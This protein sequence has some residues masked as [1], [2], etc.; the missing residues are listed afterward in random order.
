MIRK[1]NQ[2]LI[3]FILHLSASPLA[4]AI[5]NETW[6]DFSDIGVNTLLF[7]AMIIP[8]VKGD[9]EGTKQALFSIG[10]ARAASALTKSIIRSKRP[11]L[12]DNNSFPSG[13]TA[14]AFAS[15]TTLY[16]RYG[17]EMGFS[18]YAL[19]TLTGSARVAARKH[20]WY[21]A[22][23]G[24]AL[25]TL[26]GWYFTDAFDENIQLYPWVDTKSV[27]VAFVYQW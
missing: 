17:W 5:D 6:E 22:L 21:D 7:S 2:L 18:A 24:A 12:T 8:S 16:R 27:G 23:S 4:R 3:I 19:A 1:T 15:A 20:H 9:W 14:L 25:G 26:T 11:D 13:H 10:A